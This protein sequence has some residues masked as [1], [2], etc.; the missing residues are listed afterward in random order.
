MIP[1]DGVTEVAYFKY[2]NAG[3]NI[4]AAFP[5]T[6]MAGVLPTNQLLFT[7]RP[8]I[9]YLFSDLATSSNGNGTYEYGTNEIQRRVCYGGYQSTT[10]PDYSVYPNPSYSYGFTNATE[11]NESRLE[12]G[13]KGISVLAAFDGSLI[14][15]SDPN[16]NAIEF[17]FNDDQECSFGG[18]EYGF[19]VDVSNAPGTVVFYVSDHTNC[20]NNNCNASDGIADERFATYS[21]QIICCNSQRWIQYYF[22]AYFVPDSSAPHGYI[23]RVQVVDPY[24]YYLLP[25][26]GMSLGGS[27][28]GGS[29]IP[30]SSSNLPCT[31]DITPP[32]WFRAD[33]MYGESSYL[34]S[35]IQLVNNPDNVGGTP[36]LYVGAYKVGK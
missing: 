7:P 28:G 19:F 15:N 35:G 8:S 22:Q 11:F 5:D 18:H 25:C 9:T 33:I 23:I 2:S 16:V 14:G 29:A 4:E 3:N 1:N 13:L 30:S 20:A 24:K 36:G 31:F 34:W 32:L 17:F 21:F 12:L 26:A 27:P 6:Y 10:F